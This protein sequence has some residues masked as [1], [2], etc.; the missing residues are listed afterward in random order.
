MKLFYKNILQV[1]G[2]CTFISIVHTAEL[3]NLCCICM[4]CILTKQN[5]KKCLHC[6]ATF[7]TSALFLFIY[8]YQKN[9]LGAGSFFKMMFPNIYCGDNANFC[10]K[11]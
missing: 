2:T 1:R 3:K 9:S 10:N 8:F 6:R 4:K 5:K 7:P 11:T